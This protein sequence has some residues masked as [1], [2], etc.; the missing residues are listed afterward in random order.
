MQRLAFARTFSDRRRCSDPAR[1]GAVQTFNF[2]VLQG[3]SLDNHY[4]PRTCSTPR[5]LIKCRASW[6]QGGS[7]DDDGHKAQ[8]KPTAASAWGEKICGG[9]CQVHTSLPQESKQEEED[10]QDWEHIDNRRKDNELLKSKTSLA[11]RTARILC[12]CLWLAT[13]QK[14]LV[15]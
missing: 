6:Q 5:P 1:L 15:A 3:A 7:C 13:H 14:S 8:R 10:R 2:E 9:C 11:W 4:M 12:K